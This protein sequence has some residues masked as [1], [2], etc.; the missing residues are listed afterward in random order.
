MKIVLIATIAGFALFVENIG[1][2]K[3]AQKIATIIN[4][5]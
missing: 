3:K 1:R 2:V 5:H 4:N